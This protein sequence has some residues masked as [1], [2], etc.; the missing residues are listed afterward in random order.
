[1]I[2][3]NRGK[4]V[5]KQTTVAK[6]MEVILMNKRK[7]VVVRTSCWQLGHG[8]S[9]DISILLRSISLKH[10]GHSPRRSAL[11]VKE[12]FAS[13]IISEIPGIDDSP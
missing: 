9:R 8:N 3:P 11:V 4:P 1:M 12:G 10:A 13:L 6:P 2:F 7:R 5:R